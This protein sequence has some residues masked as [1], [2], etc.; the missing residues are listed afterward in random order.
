[1]FLVEIHDET[2]NITIGKLKRCFLVLAED[3]LGSQATSQKRSRHHLAQRPIACVRTAATSVP[4]APL[5]I[6]LEAQKS[7]FSSVT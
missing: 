5:V 2:F 3:I 6:P 1:M 4:R 7:T